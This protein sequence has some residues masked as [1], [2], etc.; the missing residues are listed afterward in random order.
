MHNFRL[1]NIAVYTQVK[2]CS[3]PVN[4]QVPLECSVFIH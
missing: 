4:I 1:L 3:A 2:A